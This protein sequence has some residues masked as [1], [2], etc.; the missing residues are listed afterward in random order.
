MPQS[1]GPSLV[2]T[3]AVGRPLLPEDV[4][5]AFAKACDRAG[6]PGRTLHQLRHTAATLLLG[7]GIPL[8]VIS[9]W[10]HHSGIAV[11]AAHHAAVVPE[12]HRKA[13]DAMDR[14]LSDGAS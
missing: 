10:L 8:A 13:A 4:S 12:L 2:S 7:E 11:T 9:E 3:D 5:H 6:L 1:K 14:A